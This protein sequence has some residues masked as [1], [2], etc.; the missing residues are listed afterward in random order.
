MTQALVEW[1]IELAIAAEPYYVPTRSNW[2]GDDDG[3]V[4]IIGSGGRDALPLSLLGRGE[5]YVAAKWGEIAVVGVYY[6]PNR[7]LAQFEE[8]LGR[9]SA[10]IGRHLPGLVLVAGDLNAKS[11][12]WGSPAT[13][14]RGEVLEEWVAELGL[15]VLNRGSVHTCV[16]HNGGSIVD[17]TLGTPPVARMVFGWRVMAGSETLSDHRYIRMDVSDPSA[18]NQPRPQNRGGTPLPPP[19]GA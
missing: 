8:Y 5:G 17:I 14:A 13:N 1:R 3:S 6:S 18:G 15:L 19:L 9:V 10:E 4:A 2:L 11:V 16:R 7:D 12:V